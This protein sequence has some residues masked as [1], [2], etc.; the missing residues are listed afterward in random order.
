MTFRKHLS[1]VILVL[2]PCFV[3][4][5][6]AGPRILSFEA[7]VEQGN[8]GW[9]HNFFDLGVSKNK[10]T[11]KWMVKIMENFLKMDDLGVPPFKETPT[12]FFWNSPALFSTP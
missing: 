11:P 2:L 12:C 3:P 1:V 9:W 4:K 10:G 7:A 5:S 8:K 6:W